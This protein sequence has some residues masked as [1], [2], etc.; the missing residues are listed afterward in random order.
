MQYG[1]WRK[2]SR[3]ADGGQCVEVREATDGSA[4]QVRDT[5][6]REGGTLTFTGPQWTGFVKAVRSSTF[7]A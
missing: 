3:S 4:A 2:S 7:V 1:N 6:D 5:K